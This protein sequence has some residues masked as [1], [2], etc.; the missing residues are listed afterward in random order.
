M[1]T[2]EYKSR[3][4]DDHH[5]GPLSLVLKWEF[6]PLL[7]IS[8]P[9]FT[10]GSPIASA[11]SANMKNKAIVCWHVFEQVQFHFKQEAAIVFRNYGDECLRTWRA[12]WAAKHQGPVFH[13]CLWVLWTFLTSAPYR[14]VWA[15]ERKTSV[16][17]F[18][19]GNFLKPWFSCLEEHS[20][21]EAGSRAVQIFV[22]RTSLIYCLWFRERPISKGQGCAG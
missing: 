15:L 16:F 8:L 12:G 2:R 18:F 22:W 10:P 14:F 5:W 19:F 7:R 4:E 20:L 11:W 1:N 3:K 9:V 6:C 13:V 17:G 21:A